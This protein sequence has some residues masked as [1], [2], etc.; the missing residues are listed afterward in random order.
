VLEAKVLVNAVTGEVESSQNRLSG[1]A[2]N[3]MAF[4]KKSRGESDAH[5]QT[6]AGNPVC[7][8]V[9]DCSSVPTKNRNILIFP[10]REPGVSCQTIPFPFR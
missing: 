3:Q 10:P 4:G 5:G 9:L 7:G 1:N 8:R 2:T 6:G